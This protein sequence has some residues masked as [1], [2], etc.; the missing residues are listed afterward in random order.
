M[1][2]WLDRLKGPLLVLGLV[3]ALAA[4]GYYLVYG[5]FDVPARLLVAAAI[6]FLGSYIAIDPEGVARSLTSRSARYGA[7]SVLMSLLFIGIIALVN[8]LGVRYNQR[9]DVTA[10]QEHTLSEQTIQILSTLPGE[11]RVTAFFT[12]D[13]PQRTTA[14][15]LLE[16]YAA[17]SQGKLT[18]EMVDILAN[19]ARAEQFGIRQDATTVFQMADRRQDATFVSEQEYTSAL[20]KVVESSPKK[21]YFL[22]GH[23]E[24][25]VDSFEAQGL[26]EIKN[27]LQ[28]N[29]FQIESLNLQASKTVPEDAAV[30]VVA[31]PT[32]PLAQEEKDAIVEYVRGGGKLLLLGEPFNETGLNDLLAP[33]QVKLGQGVVVDPGSTLSQD[34]TAPVVSRYPT[35]EITERLTNV[36]MLFF[37]ATHVELPQEL[38]RGVS[39]TSLA[40]TTDRSWSNTSKTEIRFNEATD[41]RGP[42]DLAVAIEGLPEPE[43]SG[44]SGSSDGQSAEERPRPRIVVVGDA[45]FVANQFLGLGP[46]GLFV[47]GNQ[48]FLLNALNWLV[49]EKDRIVVPDRPFE[50]RSMLLTAA[51]MNLI[52]L[53][54]AVGLPLLVGL[55][56]VAVWR[57]RR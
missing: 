55:V 29:N 12:P 13:S 50:D 51:Q 40:R 5:S 22:V 9:W 28:Q 16:Q 18:Y 32:N 26:S 7:N 38:P 19:P 46:Q 25:S 11:V 4:V 35:H 45:D 6:L 49:E 31:A 21:L 24:R 53:T 52:I 43:E 17:R 34:G 36:Q 20:L 56:G 57:A 30:L 8:V 10:S 37:I 2:V 23:G 41:K 33:W 39:A 3:A 48:Q 27:A 1:S 14:E 15:D 42:L 44:A 54:S 47:P